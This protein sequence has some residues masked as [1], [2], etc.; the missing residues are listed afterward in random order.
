MN[1]PV[2]IFRKLFFAKQLVYMYGT[3][4][5][6]SDQIIFSVLESRCSGEL[7]APILQIE[8]IFVA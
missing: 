5:W 6:A 4:L 2:G 3:T 7:S 8:G 1:D